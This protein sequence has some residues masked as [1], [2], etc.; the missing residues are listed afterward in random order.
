MK[1]ITF[2]INNL[3]SS[4]GTQRVLTSL[5]NL[6]VEKYNIT[7]LVFDNKKPF[8]RIKSEIKIKK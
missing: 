4:G 3:S 6:L 2:L 5:A 1:N 7:I 8:F